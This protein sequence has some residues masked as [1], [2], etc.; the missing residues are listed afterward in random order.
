L[1]QHFYYEGSWLALLL[2]G[3]LLVIC[4]FIKRTYRITDLMIEELNESLCLT[5]DKPIT[6]CS[7]LDPKEPTA[8]IFVGAS[9]GAAMHA[10]LTIKR[11]FKDYYKNFVFVDVGVIDS[12]S[13]IGQN[14]IKQIKR[15]LQGDLDYLVEFCQSHNMPAMS[16]FDLTIDPV[17]KIG[18]IAKSLTQHF[19]N[20]AFFASQLIFPGNNWVQKIIY[21]KTVSLLQYEIYSQG[22]NMMILPVKVKIDMAKIYDK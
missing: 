21:N 14:K 7:L 18:D 8:V 13:M 22:Y 2:I 1:R 6:Q 20:C 5:V 17:G 16:R 4:L 3:I 12:F 9:R 11:T 10:L 19:D 15:S